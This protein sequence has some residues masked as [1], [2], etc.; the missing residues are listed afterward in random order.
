MAFRNGIILVV[1]AVTFSS[2]LSAE[3]RPVAPLAL[4][5]LSETSN[6]G[7]PPIPLEA[8]APGVRER[9]QSVLDRPA[10]T[11]KGQAETIQ[12][13]GEIYRWLL[14]HPDLGVKLWRQVGARVQDI[15]D[16]GDGVYVWTDDHGGEV[17]WST[18][19]RA[20][21][22]HVWFAEGKI[23]PTP[24][25]PLTSFRALAILDYREGK[26]V[27]G[28]PAI[29]H[30]VHFLLRC[31]SK[32]YALAVRILGAS[33]P[34]MAEQYLGQLQMFYGGMAWYLGQDED[35]AK[36]MYRTI[37]LSVPEEASR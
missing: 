4:K 37:G 25:L 10:L 27:R 30:Q 17:K 11:S 20:N 23:K 26:D 22:L 18:V 12:A 24:V 8:I 16:R 1:L 32:A 21:G 19:A 35:R 28:K 29:R 9:V 7:L 13:D 31:D 36:K 5:S 6:P 15:R 3:Q 2:P 14:E 33:A 34:R